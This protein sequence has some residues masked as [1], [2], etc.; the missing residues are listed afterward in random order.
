MT[1]TSALSTPQSSKA[2]VLQAM[3]DYL[4]LWVDLDSWDE[5]MYQSSYTTM[6]FSA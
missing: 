2:T 5:D 6:F 4:K 3:K 1:Q